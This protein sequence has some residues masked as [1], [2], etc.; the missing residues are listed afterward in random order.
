M[1]TLLESDAEPV[2]VIN[3]CRQ[4]I[5][6]NKAVADSWGIAEPE[7][8]LGFRLGEVLH[9]KYAFGLPHGC[10][11]THYC[12]TCGAVIAMMAAIEDNQPCEQK[13]VLTT[14][15]KGHAR[16]YCL[17]IRSQPVVVAGSRWVLIYARDITM[18]QHWANLESE[19]MQDLDNKLCFIK[20]YSEYLHDQ[21]PTQAALGRSP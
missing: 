7:K 4:I 21:I 17:L 6:F 16:D 8:A 11:T 19:F 5:A 2:L 12:A 15:K 9:S 20:N 3:S 14:D 1:Q 10:G 13:C 18:Q